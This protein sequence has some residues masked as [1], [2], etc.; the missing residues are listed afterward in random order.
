MKMHEQLR[1]NLQEID[2][3]LREVIESDIELPRPSAIYDGILRL[4]AAGGKRL[5]PILVIVGSRFGEPGLEEQ[6]RRSAAL[7]EYMHMASLVHDDVID[8]SDLRRG[9]P[10]LHT[11]TDVNT[12]VHTAN[13]MMARAVEWASVIGNKDDDDDMLR[14][15][16]I[17]SIVTDLCI[18][19]YGQLRNR[20]NFDMTMEQYLDKTRRKTALLMAECLQAGGAATNADQETKSRLFE[21]GEA[22][23]MSFQ[24]K[25]DILD[26]TAPESAIGKP[27]GADLRNGNITLPVLYALD[28]PNVAPYIRTLHAESTDD[29]MRKAIALIRE[30]G[31]IEQTEATARSYGEHALSLISKLEPHPACADL[32]ILAN[33]FI[34]AI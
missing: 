3:T 17:A 28:H 9:K 10:T 31:A 6:V 23:G 21:F 18:G 12:A 30:C 32:R 20:F 13:Y 15:A 24:I 26:F 2:A 34:H 33:T 7:L 27:A 29:E 16:Q 19:E 4:I 8:N 1:I 5:R 25:D 22:L 11:A 14:S